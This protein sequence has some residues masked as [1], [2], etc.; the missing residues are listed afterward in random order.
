MAE[1]IIIDGVRYNP[2]HEGLVAAARKRA[3]EQGE[4]T[5]KRPAKPT[6]K[7]RRPPEPTEPAAQAA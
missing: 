2:R 3:D 6:H 1:M 5:V 7:A 4:R